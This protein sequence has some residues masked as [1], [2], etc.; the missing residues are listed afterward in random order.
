MY[1]VMENTL[2][3]ILFFNCVLYISRVYLTFLLF[4]Y[5]NKSFCCTML[6]LNCIDLVNVFISNT[7]I[8]IL[9]HFSMKLHYKFYCPSKFYYPGNKYTNGC[10]IA[11]NNGLSGH[12]CKLRR[13]LPG[14]ENISLYWLVILFFCFCNFPFL[15]TITDITI[16]LHYKT[17]HTLYLHFP[18]WIDIYLCIEIIPISQVIT[19][20]MVMIRALDNF[21]FW[22]SYF[23]LNFGNRNIHFALITYY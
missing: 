17:F 15:H 8:F 3:D 19:Y 23:P 12:K 6:H 9:L 21:L 14:T 7:C 20:D 1:L 5:S 13:C 4:I 11:C 18:I 2:K 22:C 10:N 16:H